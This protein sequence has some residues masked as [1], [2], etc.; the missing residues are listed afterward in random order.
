MFPAVEQPDPFPKKRQLI[1]LALMLIKEFVSISFRG[2][3]DLRMP[4]GTRSLYSALDMFHKSRF[5]E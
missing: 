3:Q 2:V 5:I 4:R 1:R